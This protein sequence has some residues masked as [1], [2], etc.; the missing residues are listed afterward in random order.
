MF[1]F[2]EIY[3]AEDKSFAINTDEICEAA[4]ALGVLDP[5]IITSKKI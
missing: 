2:P 5:Q 3:D 1:Q 4:E